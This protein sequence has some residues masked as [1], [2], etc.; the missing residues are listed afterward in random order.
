MSATTLTKRAGQYPAGWNAKRIAPRAAM[1]EAQKRACRCQRQGLG[2]F[3][4]SDMGD[5]GSWLSSIFK[6]A[7]GA[8]LSEVIAPL[9]TGIGTAVG[10]PVGGAVGAI[11][12]NFAAGSN[13]NSATAQQIAQ[14]SGMQTYGQ[15]PAQMFAPTQAGPTIT[16]I[17]SLIGA[18]NKQ[19]LTPTPPATS[20]TV[21]D[22]RNAGGFDQKTILI[23]GGIALAALVLSRR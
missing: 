13:A 18:M 14:S 19:T 7:T 11:V 4:D 5:L 2:E 10:G 22:A 6:K 1:P 23:A 15:Q 8:K 17:I 12:G 3:Y 21:I 20:P 9:A 16:D